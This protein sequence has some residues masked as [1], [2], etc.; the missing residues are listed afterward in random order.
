MSTNTLKPRDPLGADGARHD[1]PAR[2]RPIA[3]ALVAALT[4]AA[5]VAAP[6]GA[7]A[8]YPTI[9]TSVLAQSAEIVASASAQL[10]ELTSIMST[11]SQVQRSLGQGGP[12]VADA[13]LDAL[14]VTLP[15][16][17][18][19]GTIELF[20]S[21]EP[22][23]PQLPTKVGEVPGFIKSST[24]EAERVMK[25]A[26][27]VSDWADENLF[28]TPTRGTSFSDDAA[29]I[30][31]TRLAALHD[32]AVGSY[33]IAINARARAAE[34]GDDIGRLV[35]QAGASTDLRGDI[36][37]NTAVMIMMYQQIGYLVATSSAQLQ[38]QSLQA[39]EADNRIYLPE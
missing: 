5:T 27:T 6:R 28:L 13:V 35:E 17:S 2:S 19:E 32:A 16:G 39:I 25:S 36:A 26:K 12:A 33:G 8:N 23:L 29:A 9:D 14:G 3:W 21:M 31:E 34:M 7:R 11:V 1:R 4:C 18:V 15:G 24:Q 38:L 22:R 37:V 20:K 30:K 10:S